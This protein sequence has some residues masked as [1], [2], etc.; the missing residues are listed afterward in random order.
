MTKLVDP[1]ILPIKSQKDWANLA[2]Q[3]LV[4]KD[5]GIISDEYV[6]ALEVALCYGG[7]DGQKKGFD[8]QFWLHKLTPCGP[9]SIWSRINCKK[10]WLKE[11]ENFLREEYHGICHQ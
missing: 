1:P 8:E 9:K 11:S 5:S 3:T 6:E 10:D 7:I 2:G 4:K